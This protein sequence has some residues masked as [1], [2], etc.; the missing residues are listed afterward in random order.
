MTFDLHESNEL[1]AFRIPLNSDVTLILF[2]ARSP[3]SQ[4]LLVSDGSRLVAFNNPEAA[5]A[6]VGSMF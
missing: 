5:E 1:M 2:L 4:G 3:F 6:A